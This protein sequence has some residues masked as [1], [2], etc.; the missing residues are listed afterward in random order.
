MKMKNAGK[1]KLAEGVQG[2]IRKPMKIVVAMDSFKGSLSAEQACE[3]VKKALSSVLPRLEIVVK[4]IA[5]GGE[6]TAKTMVAAQNGRLITQEVMGPLPDMKVKAGFAW[7]EKDRTA[8]IEMAAASGLPLLAPCQRNPLRTTTYGTGQLIKAACE[9]D[10]KAIL[11]AV[12]GSATVDGAVGAAM[13]LGWQFLGQ[14]NYPIGFGGEW[15]Q[16]IYRIIPPEN[17]ELPVVEVL[18]DVENPLCGERGAARV[19]GP[20]KG[21]TPKMVEQLERCLEH[22]AK[23]V[24]LQ[25]GKEINL[26]KAGA[27]GGLAGG[28]VAF[29]N[30]RLVCGI[31]AIM[32]CVRLKKY[33]SDAD[34]VLTGEGCFDGQ[35]LEGKVVSGIVKAAKE[36]N[37]RVAV[38][39]GCVALT[40]EE[41]Q[42]FGIIDAIC[43]KKDDM[44]LDYAMAH[45]GELLA[46]AAVEFAGRYLMIA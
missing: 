11:L 16:Q 4:P 9:Y 46:Q 39:A 10:P 35:S 3:T 14:D 37:T 26:P 36:T 13:A 44:S 5:D 45:A 15:L 28:A 1:A 34:W 2:I 8:L 32:E 21:A 23:I 6:G 33:L 38:L 22:L 18:C 29:M 7:F 25:I 42:K 43:A 27:A 19:F 20:Q 24:K 41:Y 31:D 30:A 17:V 40:K 12:G